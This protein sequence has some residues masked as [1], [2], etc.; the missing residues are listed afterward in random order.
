MHRT[1]VMLAGLVAFIAL[2]W[3]AVAGNAIPIER[4]LQQ[5][6]E[7]AVNQ[8]GLGWARVSVDGQIARIE[9]SAPSAEDQARAGAVV[10]TAAGPSGWLLGGIIRVENRS[11][12]AEVSPPSP[13]DSAAGDRQP[14]EAANTGSRQPAVEVEGTAG[15]GPPVALASPPLPSSPP[16]PPAAEAVPMATPALPARPPAATSP[17]PALAACQRRID[18]AVKTLTIRFPAGSPAIDAA[19]LAPL[20]R[21]A[22][23]I[24]ER[25]PGFT[26]AVG[27]HTDNR[28]RER[29]NQDLSLDRAAAVRDVLIKAGI[30]QARLKAVGYG[31][32]RPIAGN[33]TEDGRARNRRITFEALQE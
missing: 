30:P 19:S 12:V 5:A 14:A 9:G 3:L 26:V 1:I 33:D 11:M 16:S 17:S 28:G 18:A 15:N 20:Q 7:A 32:S 8:A 23:V 21:L 6:A 22:R 31:S 24:G 29:F 10:L 25:C 13:P 27:G 4:T 2:G